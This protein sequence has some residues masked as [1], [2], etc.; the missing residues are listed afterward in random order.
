MIPLKIAQEEP[1]FPDGVWM[2]MQAVEQEYLQPDIIL[3]ALKSQETPENA[4]EEMGKWLSNQVIQDLA[5]VDAELIAD[6]QEYFNAKV[7][8]FYFQSLAAAVGE[9]SEELLQKYFADDLLGTISVYE[10]FLQGG[11]PEELLGR[12]EHAKQNMLD[13]FRNDL[14]REL[15]E[16]EWPMMAVNKAFDLPAYKVFLQ[17]ASAGL[18]NLWGEYIEPQKPTPDLLR[19]E[20]VHINPP[21]QAGILD[22]LRKAG[23]QLDELGEVGSARQIDEML[24]ALAQ[25]PGG[26]VAKA[27]EQANAMAQAANGLLATIQRLRQSNLTALS[28]Q[29][30]ATLERYNQAMGLNVSQMNKILETAKLAPVQ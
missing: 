10:R 2:K 13:I 12:E 20:L 27:L 7:R 17:R 22:Q 29:A 6:I 19:Q 30:I 16:R 15:V 18:D 25:T 5:R 3:D 9:I 11:A 14:N 8:Q 21:T 23:N 28:P 24:V 1:E 26:Q 4:F